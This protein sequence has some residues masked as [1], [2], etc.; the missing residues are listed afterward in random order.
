METVN[1]RYIVDDVEKSMAFYKDNLDFKIE[2]HPAPGYALL[3]KGN[4]RLMLNQPGAGG[5]GQKMSDGTEPKAGGF[6]RIQFPVDDLESFYKKLKNKGLE[7]RNE[8]VIG[9]GGKQ[10]LLKDPSGN[11]IELFESNRR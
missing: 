3:S 9:N 2:M 4:L 5:A 8:I 1:V 6:N 11:L 7:F 10:V